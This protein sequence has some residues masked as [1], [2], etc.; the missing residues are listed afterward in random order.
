MEAGV[1]EPEF[2]SV[3]SMLSHALFS[4]PACKGVMFG[5]GFDFAS[6]Y[7]SKANDAFT[8]KDGKVTTVTNHNGGINGGITNGMP[9][10]FQT[11]FKPTP[12]IAQKQQTVNFKTHENVEVEIHG[13]HDPAIIHRARV[14]VDAM[15]AITLVDLL[16]TRHGTMYFGEER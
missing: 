11:V 13:R 4:I 12:S 15:C 3:E 10:R 2:D 16:I 9:I 6:M 8:M 1:G 14:V 5:S 7:G